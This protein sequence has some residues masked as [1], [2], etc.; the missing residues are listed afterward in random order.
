MEMIRVPI[1]TEPTVFARVLFQNGDLAGHYPF[2]AEHIEFY[3]AR[4]ACWHVV[5]L[6]GLAGSEMLVP[7]YHHSVEIEALI[8]AGIQP[9]F[10]RVDAGMKPDLEDIERKITPQT[11]S[12]YVIHYLGFPGP[13]EE[14]R[15]LAK[16]H[17]L[18]LIE[19][20]A[21]ALLSK[22]GDRPLGTFG[23]VSIFCLY[24]SLPVPHG[25]VLAFNDP[26]L[27]R[28]LKLTPPSLDSTL[29]HYAKGLLLANPAWGRLGRRIHGFLQPAG[30]AFFTSTARLPRI[31]PGAMHVDRR[32]VNVRMSRLVRRL[33]DAQNTEFIVAR[34]RKNFQ[35]LLEELAPL[36]PPVFS[37]LPA[38]VCPLFYPLAVADK[39]RVR[40][41]L[42]GRGI[43]TT[44]F[45]RQGHPLCPEAEFPEVVALRGR[46]IELPCIQNITEDEVRWMAGEVRKV[47]T[48]G[49]R[50]TAQAA[51]LLDSDGV[52]ATPGI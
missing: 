42:L 30:K 19:D 6:L 2:C 7:S 17:G 40:E 22:D 24:K 9:R 16:T 15:R 5:Q 48:S 1:S 32:F 25:G 35:I 14:M 33:V 43:A 29:S 37:Q 27:A 26:E 13:I 49:S 38:G 39:D 12:L 36:A 44:D 51:S 21:L 28:P 4:N 50:D 46:V 47:L 10:Y 45:W 31:D 34:R 41:A 11:R 23:D 52:L 18:R 3:F 20:C 8:D